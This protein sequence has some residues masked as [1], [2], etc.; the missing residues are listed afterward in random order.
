MNK[1][2]AS[3]M[4]IAL[5]AASVPTVVLAQ[6]AATSPNFATTDSDK[7]GE[8]SYAEMVTA[9]PKITEDQFKQADGDNSGGLNEKEFMIIAAATDSLSKDTPAAPATTQPK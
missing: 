9:Y 2:T 5:A 3:V 8:V 4:A 1:I 6:N 7:S